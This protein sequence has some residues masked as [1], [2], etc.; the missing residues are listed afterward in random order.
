VSLLTDSSKFGNWIAKWSSGLILA[1]LLHCI[2][3]FQSVVCFA[4]LDQL[5]CTP[6]VFREESCGLIVEPWGEIFSL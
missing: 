6:F 3:K 1:V 5:K 4:L 2:L